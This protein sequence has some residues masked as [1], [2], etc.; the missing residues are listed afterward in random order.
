M[1]NKKRVYLFVLYSY[2]KL[3][4]HNQILKEKEIANVKNRVII[5][6]VD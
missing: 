1:N 6:E 2:I 4:W 5:E 3:E